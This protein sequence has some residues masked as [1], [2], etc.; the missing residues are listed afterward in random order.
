VYVSPARRAAETAAWFLRGAGVQ[1]TEH[2]VIPG[3]AGQGASGGSPEGMAAG[4]RA[5]FDQMDDGWVALAVSHTPLVERTAFGLVGL[6]VEPMVELEG[7]L[8]EQRDDGQID[9]SELRRPRAPDTRTGTV[10]QV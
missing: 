8:I 7:L 3:L 2:A 1:L 6:E 9:V 5:L 10:D 4:L